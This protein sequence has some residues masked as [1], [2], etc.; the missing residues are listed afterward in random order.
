M[1]R[2]RRP[3]LFPRFADNPHLRGVLAQF[4]EIAVPRGTIPPHRAIVFLCYT[5]RCGSNYLAEALHSSGRL[6]LADEMLNADEI[7]AD[8]RRHGHARF[9][10]Y[11]AAHLRWRMVDGC[12]AVKVATLHLELLG[13]AGVL[14][15]CR[16]SA[17]YVFIERSDRLAQAIS[18]EI[19]RQTGQWTTR[20]TVEVPIDRLE[21]SRERIARLIES[22][23][24]DNRLFDTFFGLN[25]IVPAHVL[26]EHLV[27]DPAREVRRIGEALGMPD[28][29]FA[30]E[31][32]TLRRQGGALN[33]RWRE[34]FLAA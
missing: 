24:E 9:A 25:G 17:R 16:E 26:Y 20:A 21:F 22:F 2:D 1:R 27:A 32:L 6:N 8:V 19:A 23:A 14:D 28:L 12:F 10:D 7:A 29:R 11:L 5:N 33:A 3:I 4:G 18:F 15:H 13:Q 30:P 31:K 34:M